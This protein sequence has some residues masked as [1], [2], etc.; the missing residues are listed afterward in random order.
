M[1]KIFNFKTQ[2]NIKSWIEARDKFLD[3]IESWE[4]KLPTLDYKRRSALED[5]IDL[6]CRLD[7]ETQ[8]LFESLIEELNT[9]Q[10]IIDYNSK[11]YKKLA[12]YTDAIGGDSSIVTWLKDSDFIK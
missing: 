3:E 9:A 12:R 2:L 1:K 11:K 4:Q 10:S 5:K 7:I 6:L 8:N